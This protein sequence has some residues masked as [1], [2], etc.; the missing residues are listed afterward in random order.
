[1]VANYSRL[2]TLNLQLFSTALGLIKVWDY[3]VSHPKAGVSNQ[4]NNLIRKPFFEAFDSSGGNP[5]YM[6]VPSALS[7]RAFLLDAAN[8]VTKGQMDELY[9]NMKIAE[10]QVKTANTPA[11]KQLAGQAATAALQAIGIDL[12]RHVEC[13]EYQIFLQS[14]LQF[15]KT[16]LA[17]LNRVVPKQFM[18]HAQEGLTTPTL[19]GAYIGDIDGPL[20][21]AGLNSG[22]PPQSLHIDQFKKTAKIMKKLEEIAGIIHPNDA[23]NYRLQTNEFSSW[24]FKS[25]MLFANWKKVNHM[26][27]ME[28]LR[29]TIQ[30][31]SKHDEVHRTL[32]MLAEVQRFE[33]IILEKTLNFLSTVT[34]LTTRD[35]LDEFYRAFQQADDLYWSKPASGHPLFI[36]VNLTGGW[37]PKRANIG[38]KVAAYG[39]D[40]DHN[41]RDDRGSD[42]RQ[43]RGG[44][45]GKLTYS[46]RAKSGTCFNCGK[47]GHFQGA[48]PEK[49]DPIKAADLKSRYFKR[50]LD[51]VAATAD[52]NVLDNHED[53]HSQTISTVAT[54]DGSNKTKNKR[55]K[56]PSSKTI[57]IN[58]T[59][60]I[61]GP[62]HPSS[63]P[64]SFS[65]DATATARASPAS[66]TIQASTTPHNVRFFT[67][68]GG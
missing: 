42:R 33:T 9:Q 50:K 30:Q 25:N 20:Y 58:F 45:R 59:G 12:P 23:S 7:R 11:Q 5:D 49:E 63:N 29:G 62:S 2:A 26:D 37:P 41:P 57:S 8:V 47:K 44:G 21:V 51:R 38:D 6:S 13:M 52:I 65:V 10:N 43:G 24:K 22:H 55:T 48:C 67:A 64:S 46:E 68:S 56:F 27:V 61:D 1:M 31:Y 14:F 18:D 40:P 16:T 19:V 60:V 4:Y 35:Q 39:A 34:E 17:F 28:P 32:R 3:D 36:D 53:D 54:M 66:Q 15:G